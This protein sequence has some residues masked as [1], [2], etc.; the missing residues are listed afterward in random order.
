MNRTY[1]LVWNGS[2]RG[3]Q[4]VSELATSHTKGSASVRGGR[5]GRVVRVGAALT[6]FSLGLCVPLAHADNLLIGAGGS[7]GGNGGNGGLTGGNG[8]P[9][10]F[11]AGSGGGGSIPGTTQT[12]SSPADGSSIGTTYDYVGI[13][14]A[15][16]GG[17]GAGGITGGSGGAGE[18]DLDGA[19]LGV[20][21]SLLIGGAGGGGG[22]GNSF[23]DRG[24]NGGAGGSGMLTL[25]GGSTVTVG[26]QLIVGGLDGTGGACGCSGSGGF[27]G[28]GV[29]NLGEGSSLDLS[30]AAFIING[31]GTLNIGNAVANGATAGSITG[32]SGSIANA[33]TINFNQSDASYTFS[34]VIAGTGKVT[35]N[36]SGT[37]VLTGANTYSGGTIITAGL[38]NFSNAGNLGTGS[39]TLDGGGLQW[40]SGNT[41]DLS[42]QL[43]A[44]GS[45]GG[46]FDTNGN[47]VTLAGVLSGT[48]GVTKTGAG[49]LT[50]SGA[51]TY[52]GTTTV[53]GGVLAVGSASALGTGELDIA[54]GTTLVFGATGLTLAN[55]V[56]LDGNPAIE[57][58]S[59]TDT[60]SG[61]IADGTQPGLLD[62]TGAGT[63]T[64]SGINT[65]TGSTTISGGTLALTGSGS[66]ALSSGVTNNGTLDV[67]QTTSG[68]SIQNLSGTGTVALGSKALTLTHASGTFDGT[69]TGTGSLIK[70]GSGTL[71][72]EGNSSSFAGTTEIAGG[73][74]E[75][76][77]SDTS[78]ATLGG[79]VGVDAG[80]T[81]RGHGTVLGDIVNSGMVQPGGSIGT[82]MVRGN[83]TQA[84]SAALSIE[85]SPAAA[86]QLKV[87]GNATLGG[88]L[89]IVYDPGTYSVKQYTLVSAGSITG[90]FANVS[91]T[92]EANLNGLTPSVTYAADAVN[93]ALD[94]A[95]G[96]ASSTTIAPIDTSIYAAVGTSA[97]LGAQAQGAAL[98]DRLGQPSRSAATR[99]DGWINATGSRAR[100][101]GTNEAPGFQANRYG[102]LAGLDQQRGDYTV[103]I[104][105]GYDHTD[106]DES[107]T[108]DSGTTDTL[109]AALY[110]GR[111]FGPVNLGA[112]LGAGLDFLS[113]KRPFDPVGTAEGDHMG[114]E[115]NVGGQAS[116]VM[117]FGSVA[118][119]PRIGLRYAYFHANG[120]GESGAGGQ[121]LGVGTDNVH[122]L[123]PYADVTIDKSFG[124]ALK[125]VDAQLRLGYA[126][127]LLDTN[128]TLTVAAQDGTVFVAPGTDLP[129]SYLSAGASLTLHPKK[130]LDVSLAYDTVVNTGH[131]SV[132]QGSVRVGYQF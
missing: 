124:D 102:F 125:P 126:H 6:A 17:G 45:N 100:V 41:T 95:P 50:L 57:V 43:G 82:L 49:T 92:G 38:I 61:A 39:I 89:A 106:I 54:Q 48:G 1:R 52:A 14:G 88:T 80:G 51:N 111:S 112:T 69:F 64:L 71:I 65:Y 96:P 87:G 21:Q 85:V 116:T 66:I 83:Y 86:S 84:N 109:R 20:T 36:G 119:T 115:F 99:P 94:G 101:G 53:A 27:G 81:L 11:L 8:G 10:F 33:G 113:Q 58:D 76:G 59:G 97:I 122:S 25:T 56:V 19:A 30:G 118:V 62:K 47:D 67:S 108:G 26:N 46:V 28:A 18:L 107:M 16:G 128:R 78:T 31:A 129:R 93:L 131:A 70:Q 114:Q 42:G 3:W 22:A 35:Q 91:S 73:L 104:A 9:A 15:G 24:G 40:A 130:N 75:V 120:F 103:G 117:T 74:L 4:A 121:D 132:Q 37:T 12:V 68:A 55:P 90:T 63:L 2:I 123:Q 105:A 32:L 127:E 13:G 72:L 5:V 44:I 77:D 110:G 60:L 79:N 29:L 98:L 34:A 23:S 7:G